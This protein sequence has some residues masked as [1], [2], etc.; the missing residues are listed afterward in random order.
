MVGNIKKRRANRQN[1]LGDCDLVGINSY[2][3]IG[4][5]EKLNG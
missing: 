4:R 3:K 1:E 5:H 2:I